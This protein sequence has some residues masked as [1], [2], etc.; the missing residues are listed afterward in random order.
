MNLYL[1]EKRF[2]ILKEMEIL[3]TIVGRH[4]TNLFPKNIAC[5]IAVF[6]V[7]DP[8]EKREKEEYKALCA[9]L[10][11]TTQKDNK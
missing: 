9:T 4:V 1:K 6:L 8:N 2:I 11:R 5:D 10:Y 3:Q 7:E